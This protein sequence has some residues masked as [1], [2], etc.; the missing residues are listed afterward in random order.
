MQAGERWLLPLRLKAPHGSRNPFGFDYEL[1]L[2]ERG[3]QATGYVRAGVQDAAPQRLQQTLAQPVALLR[4]SVRERI[5]MHIENRQIGGLVAALV[6]G[7]Q[8]AIDR[9]DWDV[10]RATGVAHLVSI[11]GLYKIR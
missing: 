6:V 8:A 1:W 11:S 3:V 10:F 2:W 9:V 4:Q 7:D 5:A